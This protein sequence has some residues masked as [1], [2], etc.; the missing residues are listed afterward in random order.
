MPTENIFLAR[1]PIFDRKLNLIGYELLFRPDASENNNS[2][3]QLQGDQATSIVVFNALSEIGIQNLVGNK[4]AFINFT[5]NH[6]IN[7][8][9]ASPET[10]IIEVLEDIEPD[11]EVLEAIRA[12]KESGYT[13]ALDDFVYANKF[14]PFLE[15]A[16]I[17]KIDVLETK[18]ETLEQQ[19][20]R[21][22]KYNSILLA[23]KVED[24]T[25][26]N[27][28]QSLGFDYFQ[29]YFLSKPNL[30]T[31][32]K[33]A[34]NKMV[35]MHLLTQLQ[36]PDI[37]PE[38][39]HRIISS[40]PTLSIKL[41]R[42]VNST[43]L[44][45]VEK[46][47]SLFRA[48]VMLGLDNIKHWATMLA[49]SKCQDKPVAL[50]EQTMLRARMCELLGSVV[51]DK[52]ADIFFTIGMLSMLEAFFDT[53]MEKLLSSIS[54]SEESQDALLNHGG[55]AGLI[56]ATV[57]AYTEDQWQHIEWNKLLS[58]GINANTIHNAHLESLQWTIETTSTVFN[59]T[60]GT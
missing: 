56:L 29:G 59:T 10:I 13:I 12:L 27:R 26:L 50:Y 55:I 52:E 53:S 6:L 38:K 46:I 3:A 58:Y 48:I 32:Q 11:P 36:A 44:C 8:P 40:D 24:A 28:C 16:D 43:A 33:I 31:G 25:M 39:L 7:P 51:A 42:M 49:L 22:Q 21:L 9:P 14:Q 54:L 5:R 47:E 57:Q 60:N 4:K 17:I 41:L 15:L 2:T 18:G 23:E 1:Q 30:V 20:A 19:V 37:N 35:V 45:R 34:S